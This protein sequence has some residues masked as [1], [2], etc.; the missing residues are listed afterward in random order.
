MRV[1]ADEQRSRGAL[2]GAVFD[3]GLGDR[4]DVGFVE[5]AVQRRTTVTRRT[6]RHLLSDIVRVGL[7]RVV[8]SDQVWQIDEVFG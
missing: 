8:G 1:A 7:N 4:Q 6:E 3:D 5:G 2:R